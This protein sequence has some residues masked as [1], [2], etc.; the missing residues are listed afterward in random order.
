M[1][2][3]NTACNLPDMKCS[4][5]NVINNS[6]QSECFRIGYQKHVGQLG[7]SKSPVWTSAKM[8][9]DT[10]EVEYKSLHHCSNDK[11]MDY[12]YFHLLLFSFPENMLSEF[13]ERERETSMWDRNINWLSLVCAPMGSQT[14]WCIGWRTNHLAT[15]PGP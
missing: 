8:I 13:R 12:F 7:T 2:T 1:F 6:T 9:A 3:F 11:F 10:R 4:N 15:W 5:I 14:F